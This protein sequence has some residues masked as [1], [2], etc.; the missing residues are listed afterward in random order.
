MMLTLWAKTSGTW[1]NVVLVLLGT[2]S[3]LLLQNRL[4]PKMQSIFT[5]AVGLMTLYIGIS[6]AGALSQA[7]AG[8]IDGVILALISLAIGG[9]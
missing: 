7:T 6:M 3:G 1:I 8:G 4:S 5:Q 2:G 9:L